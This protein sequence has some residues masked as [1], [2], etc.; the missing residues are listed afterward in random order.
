MKYIVL[1]ALIFLSAQTFAT[2]C[3]YESVD[4]M[5]SKSD[6]VALGYI[7]EITKKESDKPN[8]HINS[9]MFYPT[10]IFKGSH[11]KSIEIYNDYFYKEPKGS[12]REIATQEL[13]N[14]FHNLS[15]FNVNLYISY[16][17]V[18]TNSDKVYLN[19]CSYTQPV[20]ISAN[21][22]QTIISELQNLSS[23]NKQRQQSPSG[24]TH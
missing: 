20:N 14:V 9:A 12:S 23:H 15:G 3:I 21:K 17:L 8:Y 11:E 5:F 24:R 7:K 2:S 19:Q 6:Y 13:E 18:F 16:Y 22:T 1:S 4:S 10:T